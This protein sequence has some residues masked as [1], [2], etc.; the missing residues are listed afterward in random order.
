MSDWA[1]WL[2]AIGQVLLWAGYA[3][4]VKRHAYWVRRYE[5][6]VEESKRLEIADWP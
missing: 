5:E 3:A 4:T 1:V 6:A 2:F